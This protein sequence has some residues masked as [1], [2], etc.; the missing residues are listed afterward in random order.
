MTLGLVF[1][2]L[3]LSLIV[4]DMGLYVLGRWLNRLAYVQKIK[5]RKSFVQ[6]EGLL[7]K[8]AISILLISRMIPGLRLT[9]YTAAGL[10]N[11]SIMLF[12]SLIVIASI[13][14]SGLLLR[15]GSHLVDVLAVQ[16][17]LPII[18][19]VVLSIGLIVGIQLVVKYFFFKE[20][21]RA[22]PADIT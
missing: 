9:T 10:M 5:Q 12:S 7:R 13:V 18:W 15:F 6:V 22:K 8:N 17:D 2:V 20:A 21:I 3:S 16:T 11:L 1:G 14:W 4:G 19:L